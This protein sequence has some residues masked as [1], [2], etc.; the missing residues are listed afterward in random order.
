MENITSIDK[1]VEYYRNNQKTQVLDENMRAQA[2][3]E[4]S[5]IYSTAQNRTLDS[6][7]RMM[8]SIYE[9][10]GYETAYHG[11]ERYVYYHNLPVTGILHRHEFIEIFYVIDGYFEQ[12]L[13]GEKHHFNAGEFV[14]TDQNCEHSDYLVPTEASVLFLQIKSE[15]LDEILHR[16]DE[17]DELKKFLFHALSRQKKEQSFLKLKEMNE[18]RKQTL[19][20]LE[21]L[22]CEYEEKAPGFE[23]I[24]KGLIIRL[25]QHICVNYS[26]ELKTDTKESKEKAILYELERFIRLHFKEVDAIMLESTF[27][28]HRNYYNLLFKKYLG[29]TFKEYLTEVRMKKAHELFKTTNLPINEIIGMVGYKNTSHFY[30]KYEE[31]Y[32]HGPR[33]ETK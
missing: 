24:S 30:H 23:E 25:L 12:I 11:K 6:P 15:Y 21:K 1:R 29:V 2:I 20:L 22:F 32:G 26:P 7:L 28:Y 33:K 3:T 19:I 18:S 4:K 13:L 9:K 16:F 5:T 27:H 31:T 14:I 17:Q 8:I 10:N